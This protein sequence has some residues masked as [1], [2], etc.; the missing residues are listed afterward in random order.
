MWIGCDS[1]TALRENAQTASISV[2][3]V[4]DLTSQNS[5]TEKLCG[6]G[7]HFYCRTSCLSLHNVGVGILRSGVIVKSVRNLGH[8]ASEMRKIFSIPS[9]VE[10]RV[11]AKCMENT[12]DLLDNVEYAVHEA[13]LY[14]QQ[15]KYME[16]SYDLLDNMEYTAHEAGLYDQQ[17]HMSLKTDIK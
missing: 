4:W 15:A 6:R 8:I 3:S 9:E 5:K 10:T 12:Y 2:G 11:W 13:G 7:H 16:N 17:V 14:D 1:T